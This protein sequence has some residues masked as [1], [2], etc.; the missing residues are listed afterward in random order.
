M[1]E[2]AVRAALTAFF[3]ALLRHYP[4][5]L[6]L[7][8]RVSAGRDAIDTP[9]LAAQQRDPQLQAVRACRRAPKRSL[10]TSRASAAAPRGVAEL[11]AAADGVAGRGAGALAVLGNVSAR[12]H[13]QL[14]LGGSGG[15]GG[16]GGCASV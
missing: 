8:A 9:A 10:L 15:R 3:A 1:D 14:V 13:S 16:A 6:R 12:A 5:H 4:D 7:G 2:A 11:A